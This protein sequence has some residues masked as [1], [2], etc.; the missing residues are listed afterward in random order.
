MALGSLLPWLCW[1]Q[2]ILQVSQVGV[3]K[4]F[5]GLRSL[6]DL[7]HRPCPMA[8]LGSALVVTLCGGPAST[9][10]ELC[11]PAEKAPHRCCQGLG[12]VPSRR[13]A[14]RPAC[15]QVPPEQNLGWS[16]SMAP[17]FEKPSQQCETA[18]DSDGTS[19]EIILLSRPRTLGLH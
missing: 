5:S 18:L 13:T 17:E 9:A 1:A 15:H 3:P 7:G 14:T 6:G 11:E 12:P 16:L 2:P 19:F 4:A 10:L 8:V